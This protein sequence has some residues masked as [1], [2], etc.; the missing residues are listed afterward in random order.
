MM[1]SHQEISLF[2]SIVHSGEKQPLDIIFAVVIII[3]L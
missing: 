1:A 2:K 3:S